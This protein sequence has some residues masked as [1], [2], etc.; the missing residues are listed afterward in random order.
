MDWRQE[1]GE[2]EGGEEGSERVERGEA[3]TQSLQV[4]L[5][6]LLGDKLV[7]AGEVGRHGPGWPRWKSRFQENVRDWGRMK[8]VSSDRWGWE[9]PS[10]ALHTLRLPV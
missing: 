4:V 9:S 7:V 6:V 1:E 10:Q 3:I 8:G 2:E 5:Q